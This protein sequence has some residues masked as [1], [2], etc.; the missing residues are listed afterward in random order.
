MGISH[1]LL[2]SIG[3][4]T[5]RDFPGKDTGVGCLFLPQGIFLTQGP[6]SPK[7]LAISGGFFTTKPADTLSEA[8]A[9]VFTDERA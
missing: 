8:A 2:H 3:I 1:T 6:T 4:P 5:Q 7:S 9:I